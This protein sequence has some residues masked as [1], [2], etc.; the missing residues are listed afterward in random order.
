MWGAELQPLALA[1]GLHNLLYGVVWTVAWVKV[2]EARYSIAHWWIGN[3][4]GAAGFGLIGLR[5]EGQGFWTH[6]GANLCLIGYAMAHVRAASVFLHKPTADVEN[7]SVLALCALGLVLVG[8]GPEF[9]AHRVVLVNAAGAWI[10]FRSLWRT[11]RCTLHE[12]GPLMLVCTGVPSL[13]FAGLC[14]VRVVL[15][16]ATPAEVLDVH[17]RGLL[18]FLALF[19]IAG[20][21]VFMNLMYFLQIVLRMKHR[22]ETLAL[23]D[24]LTGLLNRRGLQSELESAWTDHEAQG[25]PFAVLC[26]D[27]DR[28][29]RINDEH[30]HAVGDLA[31]QHVAHAMRSCV[32]PYDVCAR[33]G[34]EEFVLLMPGTRLDEAVQVGERLRVSMQAPSHAVSLHAC[35]CVTVSLGA[36][37]V[38]MGDDSP[39]AVLHRADRALYRAKREGRD[40]LVPFW[41]DS[42]RRPSLMSMP[43]QGSA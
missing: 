33:S 43:L 3:L 31:L 36:A 35:P 38:E 14:A 42:E 10:L 26:L 7:L 37:M 30:G 9:S 24:P 1:L 15:A 32:S 27:V 18:N 29:K 11:W 6:I 23:T 2:G 20:F 17:R 13:V 19:S 34:G 22:L 5:D 25:R 12:F 39:E 28:F 41:R 21:M 8:S 4:F 16:L 40:R